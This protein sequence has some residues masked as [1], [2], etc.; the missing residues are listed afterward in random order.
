M[1]RP[2]RSSPTAFTLVEL[3]VVIGIISLLIALLLPAL[4]KAREAAKDVQCRSNLRQLLSAC[5][6]YAH[7]NHGWFPTRG[8][9]DDFYGTR[10]WFRGGV[11]GNRWTTNSSHAN[12]PTDR[13]AATKLAPR[14]VT[15][16]V[17]FCPSNPPTV[18]NHM[19]VE[20][21]R[22]Y[23]AFLDARTTANA[24]RA[25]TGFNPAWP[26][27]R[28]V[29][30]Y[31]TQRGGAKS[32]GI[33]RFIGPLRVSEPGYLPLFADVSQ[34]GDYTSAKVKWLRA[35]HSG[36]NNVG[37]ADGSVYAIQL[38]G[39]TDFSSVYF[40]HDMAGR[41]QSVF[42]GSLGELKDLPAR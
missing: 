3:L 27:N 24:W 37:R 22:K 15:P 39:R 10:A 20:Y 29:S 7:D 16:A 21:W 13:E 9:D 8:L 1:H 25:E 26:G 36:R 33:F 28:N 2:C 19:D 38:V 34:S 11:Y 4:N 17:F 14:Y 6:L 40:E 42:E 23:A 30:Y 35:R 5:H 18:A 32:G 12:P 41:H 31:M